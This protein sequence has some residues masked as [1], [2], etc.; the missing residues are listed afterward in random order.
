MRKAGILAMLGLFVLTL[1]TPMA[2]MAGSTGRRNTA[3]VLGAASIY[4]LMKGKT[5]Q[6]VV[7]GAGTYYAYK[8]YKDAKD[9]ENRYNRRTSYNRYRSYNYH[10]R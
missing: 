4:S 2:A 6:G 5:T 8:K 10:H 3:I 9:Q 7:L 1:I